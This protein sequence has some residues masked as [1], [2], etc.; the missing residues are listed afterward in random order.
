MSAKF[1]TTIGFERRYNA[2][3]QAESR[4]EFIDFMIG[5][6]PPRP[7]NMLHIVRVNQGRAPYSL[8][9]PIAAPLDPFEVETQAAEGA[10]IIDTRSAAAFGAGHIAGSLNAIGSSNQFEQYVGWTVPPDP[11]LILV[12]EDDRHVSDLLRRLAFV[13]LDGRVAGFLEHGIGAWRGTGKPLATL[14]Q[15]TVAEL[16]ALRQREPIPVL[17]VREPNEWYSGRIP[18]AVNQSY[19]QLIAQLTALPFDPQLF[20]AVVCASGVRSSLAASILAR[21]GYANLM[22]VVEGT[23][24]WHRAGFEMEK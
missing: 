11:P 21:Y 23:N 19:R 16:H 22:N 17:D 10:M 13:G 2:A 24:G 1:G 5:N 4:E 12:V 6:L 20:L 18:G 7:A 8:N 15:I 14:R 3:L 9:D